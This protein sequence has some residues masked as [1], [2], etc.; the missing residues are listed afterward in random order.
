MATYVIEVTE[1][2]SEA[3]CD[4]R[5]HLEAENGQKPDWNDNYSNFELEWEAGSVAYRT[6]RQTSVQW[7]KGSIPPFGKI[8]LWKGD[9]LDFLNVT[10]QPRHQKAF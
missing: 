10:G 2:N 3:I 1:F 5:G 6:R 9:F 7:V 4:L 8:I